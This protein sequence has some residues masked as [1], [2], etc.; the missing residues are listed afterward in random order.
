MSDNK[1][2]RRC[3]EVII[4]LAVTVLLPVFV[5]DIADFRESLMSLLNTDKFCVNL[6]KNFF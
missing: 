1:A 5:L 2:R 4:S 6:K 3:H